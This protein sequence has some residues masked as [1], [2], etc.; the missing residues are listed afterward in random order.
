[1][2]KSLQ[3]LSP[4]FHMLPKD[5]TGFS[6]QET[7][8]RQR[9]LDLIV[10]NARPLACGAIFMD[11]K[12]LPRSTPEHYVERGLQK[13]RKKVPTIRSLARNYCSISSAVGF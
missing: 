5:H 10:N 1:M 3:L 9:Y 2:A 7:R 13:R 8:Y 6:D 4:C 12:G 11:R